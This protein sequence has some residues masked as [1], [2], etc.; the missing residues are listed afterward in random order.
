MID[1]KSFGEDQT[2]VFNDYSTISEWFVE[3]SNNSE[4]EM[5]PFKQKETKSL[6]EKYGTSNFVWTGVIS[7][8]NKKEG[9]GWYFCLAIY[10][11]T[12]PLIVYAAITPSY[13]TDYIQATFDINSGENLMTNY[14][15]FTTS[16]R[17]DIM[18]SNI[19]DY[20]NQIKDTLISKA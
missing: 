15:Q 17:R 9:L 12:I 11:V 16:D 8:R 7:H 6:I 18:N 3:K 4:L 1:S 5:V 20:L 19:Y 10:P 13:T 2:D 14:K